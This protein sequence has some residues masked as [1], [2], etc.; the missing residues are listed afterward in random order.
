MHL[1]APQGG[2]VRVA[3]QALN[4]LNAGE[5]RDAMRHL[6]MVFQDPIS[7]LNPRRRIADI[8]AEPLEIWGAGG[9]QA[10]R[11]KVAAAL[12]EVGIRSRHRLAAP[13]PRAVRRPV[14]A[15][16][17]CARADARALGAGAATS[18]YR[19]WMCRCRRRS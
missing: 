1:P 14:P 9:A 12:S 19:R 3:G 15:G 10:N 17:D 11:P 7:S 16:G 5:R 18:R 6:Q 4:T 8:V 2:T 13:P